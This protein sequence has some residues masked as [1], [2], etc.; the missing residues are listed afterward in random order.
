MVVVGVG[1][2]YKLVGRGVVG[3][4]RRDWTDMT[5]TMALEVGWAVR[6]LGRKE[7]EGFKKKETKK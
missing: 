5:T 1:V 4:G 7:K 2:V 3:R 6:N